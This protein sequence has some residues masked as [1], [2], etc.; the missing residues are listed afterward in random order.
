MTG[1]PSESFDIDETAEFDDGILS[2]A[3]A[4]EELHFALTCTA[5]GTTPHAGGVSKTPS[6]QSVLSSH[7]TFS[8]F[9]AIHIHASPGRCPGRCHLQLA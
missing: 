9:N 3:S 8:V 1:R 2:S 7:F 5:V 4:Y 6:R